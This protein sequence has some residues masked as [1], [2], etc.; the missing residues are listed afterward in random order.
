M[1]QLAPNGPVYQAGTLAG[2]PVATAAGLAVLSL[3]DDADYKE[4]AAFAGRL[5]AGLAAAAQGSGLEV[6]IPVAGPL[7]GIFFG[8]A[9]VPDYDGARASAATGLFPGVM[10]GLLAEGVAIAP[11]PYEA[12][13]PSLA[14]G[15]AE[16]ERTVAA[17]AKV[18]RSVARAQ[19]PRG[20]GS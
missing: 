14:H 10:R 17:F 11:G 6:Q 2:N 19:P 8:T 18:T 5:G 7:L 15:P 13:F 16:L 12:L 1:E 9:P 3:L 20:G 4:L